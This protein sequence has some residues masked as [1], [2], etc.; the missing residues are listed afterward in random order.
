MGKGAAVFWGFVVPWLAYVV[1]SPFLNIFNPET[2]SP[3]ILGMPPLVFWDILWI[4]LTPFCL[5][6]AYNIEK[7]RWS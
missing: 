1:I 7:R 4:V 2:K 3:L 6:I 5:L